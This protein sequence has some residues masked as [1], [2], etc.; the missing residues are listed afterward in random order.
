VQ[1]DADE[2][3]SMQSESSANNLTLESIANDKEG[4]VQELKPL[5]GFKSVQALKKRAD[6]AFKQ[7]DIE[8]GE[9]PISKIFSTQTRISRDHYRE[10]LKAWQ[11]MHPSKV[12]PKWQ[13]GV[14]K[15]A[16]FQICEWYH[17]AAQGYEMILYHHQ[18]CVA[19]AALATAAGL[20][21]KTLSSVVDVNKKQRSGC[22]LL[23]MPS[24]V[25]RNIFSFIKLDGELPNEEIDEVYERLVQ[26]YY[27]TCQD[28]KIKRFFL[29][30]F[31]TN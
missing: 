12:L 23:T 17:E 28:E 22:N 15:T 10:K 13:D 25:M 5:V 19:A 24:T 29:I 7:G 16:L 6:G 21:L 8:L 20:D 1:S 4:T 3:A 14:P 18:N 31:Q 26:S 11:R 2:R 9:L 27:E 30:P